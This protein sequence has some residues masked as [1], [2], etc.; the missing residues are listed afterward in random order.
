[1]T[2][3]ASGYDYVELLRSSTTPLE[4]R[5]SAETARKAHTSAM[6]AEVN[7]AYN[8]YIELEQ[9]YLDAVK[10]ANATQTAAGKRA[11]IQAANTACMEL[12][13][14][15]HELQSAKYPH[16][17]NRKETIP[18]KY[19]VPNSD[20]ERELTITR[21]MSIPSYARERVVAAAPAG[22]TA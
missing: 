20:P 16:R 3:P 14:A 19:A 22:E 21:L 2:A 10:E 5:A 4:L 17:Y 13:D 8:T 1:M 7:S 9:V 15:A 12:M 18:L 11:A 6:R